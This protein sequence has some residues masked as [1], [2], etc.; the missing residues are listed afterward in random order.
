MPALLLGL[1]PQDA[2]AGPESRRSQG[3]S[4]RPGHGLWSLGLGILLYSFLWRWQSVV[5]SDLLCFLS[6]RSSLDSSFL[7]CKPGIGTL[8]SQACCE[9]GV[10]RSVQGWHT[11][12]AL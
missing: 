8:P 7:I 2:V 3:A 4:W 10:N 11:G 9:E 5:E 1:G 6:D 12:D